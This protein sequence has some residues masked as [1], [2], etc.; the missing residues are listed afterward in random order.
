[1]SSPRITQSLLMPVYEYECRQCGHCFEHLVLHSSP[2]AECPD[3]RQKDLEQLVSRCAVSSET[4]RQ[5]NL[6]AAHQR[7]AGVRKEKLRQGH[8]H[9]HEHFED[10][11]NAGHIEKAGPS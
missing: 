6:S 2:P 3:C 8:T 9:L 1:V 11:P 5:A 4:T 7:A 10:R